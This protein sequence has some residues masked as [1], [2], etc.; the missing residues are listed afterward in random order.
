MGL[1]QLAYAFLPWR[2]PTPAV[3]CDW[4]RHQW[5]DPEDSLRSARTGYRFAFCRRCPASWALE[6]V[7]PVPAPLP[8]PRWS[9]VS[10]AGG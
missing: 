7:T 1:P 10:A 5:R 6:P 3:P 9:P 2:D 4:G 8:A